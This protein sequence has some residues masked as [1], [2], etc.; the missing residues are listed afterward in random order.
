M[1]TEELIGLDYNSEVILHI[2]T[3][4]FPLQALVDALLATCDPDL[5]DGLRVDDDRRVGGALLHGL[6]LQALQHGA[7][8][9]LHPPHPGILLRLQ[10]SG[11]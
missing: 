1:K 4:N 9:L 3:A 8:P 11:M 7:A 10:H 5:A 2:L 6:P